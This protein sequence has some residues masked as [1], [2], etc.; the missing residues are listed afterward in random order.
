MN[1]TIPRPT[2]TQHAQLPTAEHGSLL[3]VWNAMEPSTGPTAIRVIGHPGE[4]PLGGIPVLCSACDARR[5]WLFIN[6]GRHVWIRCRCGHHWAE[7]EITRADFDHL[8]RQAQPNRMHYPTVAAAMAD[9][10]F[11]GTFA[12][13]YLG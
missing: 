9:L 11:D 12:G 7:P 3:Q 6:Q 13:L 1:R 10:G 8:L 5:D 4:Y 2:T